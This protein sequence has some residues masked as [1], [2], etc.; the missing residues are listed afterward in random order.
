MHDSAA[1]A[2]HTVPNAPA[3]GAAPAGGDEAA[4]AGAADVCHDLPNGAS[5]ECCPPDQCSGEPKLDG[6]GQPCPTPLQWQQVLASF[7]SQADEFTVVRAGRT[8]HGRAL[9]EGHPVYFL[10]GLG[11]THE[12]FALTAWLLRDVFRCVLFDSPSPSRAASPENAASALSQL[13]SDLLATADLHGHASFSLYATSFGSLVALDA[14]R[15]APQRIERAVLQGGF[16]RLRLSPFE[17]MLLSL[18]RL[19]PGRLKHLPLRNVIQIQSHRPW[20]PPFDDTRWQFFSQ[21]TGGVP[22]RLLARRAAALPGCDL[23]PSLPHIAA[24][25]LLIRGEGEG[26]VSAAAHEELKAG[27]PNAQSEWMAGCG[28]LPY[29]THPHRLVKL[30]RAYFQNQPLPT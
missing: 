8:F 30:L 13:T 9:G 12:L 27:L 18:G 23:R 6:G 11:G 22:L 7:R 1:P 21:D 24:P 25:V 17:R 26:R 10:N 16:A 3:C 28:H 4:C 15:Q 14:M 20:F 29:L 19:L 2:L 5:G